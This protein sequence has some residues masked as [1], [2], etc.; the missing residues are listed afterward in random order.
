[1]ALWILS[2]SC[3]EVKYMIFDTYRFGSSDNSLKYFKFRYFVT[4][5]LSK[6]WQSV[7]IFVDNFS[8]KIQRI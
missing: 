5:C 2:L 8:W 6:D 3:F 4:L 1:M 7:I